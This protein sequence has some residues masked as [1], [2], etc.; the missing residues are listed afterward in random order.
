MDTYWD[1]AVAY[2]LE[3]G[4]WKFAL[5]TAQ[6]YSND[7]YDTPFGFTYQF[8]IPSDWTH[9]YQMS[10]SDRF[11]PALTD[12]QCQ[13]E[14]GYWYA[15][16]DPLYVRYIS[17][18]ADY[19]NDLSA[20]SETYTDFI[21]SRLAFLAAPRLTDNNEIVKILE[22]R[23]KKARIR[24]RAND[25]MNGNPA[26]AQSGSWARSRRGFM[27]ADKARGTLIG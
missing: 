7:G 14:A 26:F 9:T 12:A 16:T 2:G 22:D 8:T 20:W 5:K 3:Q 6:I 27:P 25:A 19:G 21:A 4:F 15:D 11:D 17:N 13:E 18:A 10:S 23:E 1:D 24:A